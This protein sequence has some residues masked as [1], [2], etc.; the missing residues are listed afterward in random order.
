MKFRGDAMKTWCIM[1]GVI[2]KSK[3]NKSS[4]PLKIVTDITEILG[5]T[6]IA[7]E[8]NNFFTDIG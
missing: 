1:K 6:N 8:F 2:G 7:N 3:I 5:E 4:L